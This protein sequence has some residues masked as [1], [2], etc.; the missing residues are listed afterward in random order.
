MPGVPPESA[1]EK[2]KETSSEL[3][4]INPAW[5]RL[6]YVNMLFSENVSLIKVCERKEGPSYMPIVNGG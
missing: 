4:K 6:Q 2:R 5:T 1:H 3:A